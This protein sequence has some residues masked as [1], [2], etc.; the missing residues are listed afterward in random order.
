MVGKTRRM[1][2]ALA[3]LTDLAV[4]LG[5]KDGLACALAWYEALEKKGILWRTGDSS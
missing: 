3:L 2:L 5:R 4:E 1:L